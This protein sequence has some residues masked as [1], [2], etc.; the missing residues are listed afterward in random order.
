MTRNPLFHVG[1]VTISV[2]MDVMRFLGCRPPNAGGPSP[3]RISFFANN[4]PCTASGR[5]NP[6]RATDPIRLALVLLARCFA[7]REALTIGQPATLRR[8]HRN[9]FCLVWRWRSRPGRLPLP[10]ELQRLRAAT[11]RE[12]ITW[13][14]E[15]IAAELLLKL[16]IRV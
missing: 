13:G 5:W 8:W 1:R 16:G 11:A 14:E 9:A 15:R 6:R 4:W 2:T 10:S 3:R 12:N 7:W